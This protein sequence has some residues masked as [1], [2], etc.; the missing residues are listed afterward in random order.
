MLRSDLG[1]YNDVYIAVKER[2]TVTGTN[3]ANRR[4]KNQ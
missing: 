1:D 3:V 4:I 2:I